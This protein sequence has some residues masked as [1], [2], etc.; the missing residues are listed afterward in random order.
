MYRLFEKAMLWELIPYERNPI[1]LVELK[2]V[3]K[4]LRPP[5]ILTEDEFVALLNHCFNPT[6]PWFSWR[7]APDCVSA[8]FSDFAG[9]RWTSSAWSWW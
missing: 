7:A 6:N 2:G 1:G 4:R 9:S 8:R 3:S 5:R